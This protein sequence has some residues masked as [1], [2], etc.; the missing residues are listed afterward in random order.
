[1][2]IQDCFVTKLVQLR[3]YSVNLQI[4]MF[5]ELKIIIALGN[6]L[7]QNV[8]LVHFVLQ[9]VIVAAKDRSVEVL[10]FTLWVSECFSLIMSYFRIRL[11]VGNPKTWTKCLILIQY[12]LWQIRVMV[13]PF[14]TVVPM[15]MNTMCL[16]LFQFLPCDWFVVLLCSPVLCQFVIPLCMKK[17]QTGLFF[18]HMIVDFPC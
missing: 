15:A 18:F 6:F 10:F 11:A 7:L 12:E 3:Q 1:M 4:M 16:S 14:P 13:F 8:S 17:F 9:I 2:N 5:V